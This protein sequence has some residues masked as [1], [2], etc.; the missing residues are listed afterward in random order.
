MGDDGK[1]KYT[2]T[3]VGVTPNLKRVT[4]PLREINNRLSSYR[5]AAPALIEGRQL[6]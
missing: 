1:W 5:D 4:F 3:C 2:V 6:A